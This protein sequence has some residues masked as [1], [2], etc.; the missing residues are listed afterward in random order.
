MRSRTVTRTR[1][2]TIGSSIEMLPSSSIGDLEI[3]GGGGSADAGDVVGIVGR[4]RDL[5]QLSNGRSTT[6][7]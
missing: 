4:E 2:P 7:S 1:M 6:R 3:V 5:D